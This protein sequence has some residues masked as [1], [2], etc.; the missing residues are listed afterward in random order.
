M[1]LATTGIATKTP[2]SLTPTPT[3]TYIFNNAWLQARERMQAAGAYLDP[4][5]HA[6]IRTYRNQCGMVLLG[7]GCS[8]HRTARARTFDLVHAR[9][10]LSHLPDRVAVPTKLVRSLKPGGW[11]SSALRAIPLNHFV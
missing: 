9:L 8:R 5:D 6:S 11:I 1:S 7:S 2:A 4:V 10:L 3:S